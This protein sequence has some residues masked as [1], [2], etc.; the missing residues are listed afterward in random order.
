MPTLAPCPLRSVEQERV[1]GIWEATAIE[2]QTVAGT[3]PL[4]RYIPPWGNDSVTVALRV[5]LKQSGGG[6]ELARGHPPGYRGT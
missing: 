5:L 6:I 1:Q 3:Y 2:G 4:P